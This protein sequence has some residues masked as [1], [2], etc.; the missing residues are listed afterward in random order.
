M[1]THEDLRKLPTFV[2]IQ[3]GDGVGAELVEGHDALRTLF[4]DSMWFGGHEDL[5]EDIEREAN[6]CGD[7]EHEEW[8]GFP[9]QLSFSYEDGHIQIVQL[10]EPLSLLDKIETLES[11]F[12][13]MYS[14][15]MFH[16]DADMPRM[17]QTFYIGPKIGE[18]GKNRAD[19]LKAERDALKA[20]LAGA[21]EA[22]G[23]I[24]MASGMPLPNPEGVLQSINKDA[25]MALSR[26]RSAKGDTN[27][28]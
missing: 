19:D 11:M 2:F 8:E 16:G 1:T 14:V 13:A 4:I 25:K 27:D 17:V 9:R 18:R 5:P 26:T 7:P 24:A 6:I 12:D 21:E 15:G 3:H 22:L 28:G 10:T 20:Q 23:I